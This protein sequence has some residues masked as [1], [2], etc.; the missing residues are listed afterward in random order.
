MILPP[1]K[2][3]APGTT[4]D[5]REC[6]YGLVQ[7]R[8]KH[9]PAHSP[10][11]HDRTLMRAHKEVRGQQ[12]RCKDDVL[13]DPAFTVSRRECRVKSGPAAGHKANALNSVCDSAP[14]D[15]E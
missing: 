13:R 10:P 9:I 1:F 15:L 8:Y 6:S 14:L 2:T 12:T 4:H 5:V 3:A 11:M 7:A